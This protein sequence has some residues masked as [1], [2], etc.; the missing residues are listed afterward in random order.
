MALQALGRITFNKVLDG[1][2]GTF[3]LVP[4]V[5]TQIKSKDPTSFAPDFSKNYLTITPYLTI[6]GIGSDNNTNLIAGTCTWTIDGRAINGTTEVAE[7]SGQYRLLIKHNLDKP[8]LVH[9]IYGWTHPSTGQMLKFNGSCV[10]NVV[11]NA[12]TVIMAQIVP[13]TVNNFKTLAG[14]SQNLTFTGYMVRG[15]SYDTTQV[16]YRW[17]I[18]APATGKY[19]DIPAN[20]NLPAGLGLPTGK[21]LFTFNGNKITV[22]SDAVVNVGGIKLIVTDTDKDSTTY[23]KT[24][25]A[26]YTLID[27]TDPIDII[28]VPL[29]G[30]NIAST[31]TGSRVRLDV[32]Q[33]GEAWSTALYNGKKLGF[34][35]LTTS[36]EKDAT[37]NPPASDFDGWTKETDSTG[38]ITGALTRSYSS[39]TPGNEA[40]RTINIKYD[41]LLTNSVQTSFQSTLE[42]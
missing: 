23:Q 8:I 6:M 10:V 11:E 1:I 4:S 28:M 33:G 5:G 16:N 30:F 22:N 32:V 24:A 25:E 35:R 36:D 41:H 15:G 21:Q 37:F 14:I 17:Q 13:D 2:S 19:A 34:Y 29:G 40:N 31:S 7:T 9:C 18:F 12:G 42:F 20:G 26:V 3:S 39:T 27:D 38:K